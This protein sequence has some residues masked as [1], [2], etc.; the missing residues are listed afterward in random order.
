MGNGTRNNLGREANLSIDWWSQTLL[1][2]PLVSNVMALQNMH[3]SNHRVSIH[4]MYYKIA[5]EQAETFA[6]RDAELIALQR[7]PVEDQY[8]D[9]R[10]IEECYGERERA[11]VIAVTFAGM[12]IEAFFYDYAA[13]HVGD[14]FVKD[15]LDKLDVKSKFLVYPRIAGVNS[16]DKR[17]KAYGCLK[18]L[19]SL[20]NELVHFKSRSFDLSELDKFHSEFGQKL[21]DGVK[22]AIECVLLIASELDQLH[23]QGSLYAMR[24]KWSI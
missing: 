9:S 10:R 3:K 21:K 1:W 11:A 12:S 7:A 19:V 16:P 24:M 17:G 23:G 15:N 18:S 6:A 5:C 4:A 22:N 20:R 14:S 2:L 8:V 13:E